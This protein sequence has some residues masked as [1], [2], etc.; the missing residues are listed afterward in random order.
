MPPTNSVNL[1][2]SYAPEDDELRVRL[3]KHL[4]VLKREGAIRG[5]SDRM[6]SAG[7]EWKG[8]ID[9]RLDEADII[10]LLVSASYLASDYCYDVEVSRALE[11]HERGQA[12]VIPVI[13]RPCDWKN[14]PFGKL[15]ALPSNGQ[16]VTGFADI[17]AALAEIAAALREEAYKR[18]GPNPSSAH[19]LA[20]PSR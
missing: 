12:T 18:L 5:W 15:R 17:E 19:L 20:A 11:R 10:L 3:E 7:E 9:R 14:A 6:I 2:F 1:F 16:P 4:A 8:E 13:L